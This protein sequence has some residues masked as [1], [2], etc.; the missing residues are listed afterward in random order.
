MTPSPPPASSGTP[1]RWH[2]GLDIGGTK[3]AGGLVDARTGAV[4]AQRRIPTGAG[5]G[6]HAVARDLVSLA[7][8]LASEATGRGGT[9][10]G[11][12][13]G[14]AELVD[15]IGG[16]RSAHLTDWTGVSLE[17][18]LGHLGPV[19]V[20]SDVRAAALGEARFG[21]GRPYPLFTYVT[22]GTGISSCLVQEGIP[23]AGSRGNAL[24]L[25][26]APTTSTCRHCG[27]SQDEVLE[28]IASGPAIVTRYNARA[29][30]SLGTA[31]EVVAAV[32][33]GDD[34]AREVVTSAGAALGNSVGWLVNVLDPDAVVIGGGL[35]LAG[36]VYWESVVAST[37][38]HIWSDETR[39]L[40]IIPAGLGADS[41]VIGAAL[42]ASPA[43]EAAASAG[44]AGSTQQQRSEP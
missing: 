14:V 16:I 23:F 43:S 6:G 5:R 41:G 7:E 34:D 27:T 28:E 42:S 9:V 30:R 3:I 38:A 22:V 37:R 20:E 36:A 1:G 35:G 10:A 15:P 32:A 11:V 29:N 13:V 4:L 21:A 25:A 18:V 26:S 40:P 12:G 8:G 2:I 33:L 31:Q 17:A 24:V 44:A 39:D 19:T